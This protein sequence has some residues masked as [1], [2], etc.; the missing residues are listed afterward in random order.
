MEGMS[1]ECRVGLGYPARLPFWNLCAV[2][3][4]SSC[5][6]LGQMESSQELWFVTAPAPLIIAPHHLCDHIILMSQLGCQESEQMFHQIHER[7]AVRPAYSLMKP[8]APAHERPER[9]F[10]PPYH[11]GCLYKIAAVAN[12]IPVSRKPL[13]P[14]EGWKIHCFG[15]EY[16]VRRMRIIGHVPF[17]VVPDYRG[18]TQAFE[19]SNLNFLGA[20][21]NQP[22]ESSGKAFDIFSRQPGNQI[23]VDMNP[24]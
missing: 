23:R 24:C 4:R 9:P 7:D 5:L 22:I 19:N 13:E 8:F 10:L 14:L 18:A 17:S 20:K 6:R 11:G 21:V 15:L 16:F 1:V 12:Q 2:F 3:R